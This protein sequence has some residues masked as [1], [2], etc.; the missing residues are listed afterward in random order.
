M[1]YLSLSRRCNF[2]PGLWARAHRLFAAAV[3]ALPLAF[4]L[5]A[6]DVTADQLR[7][8]ANVNMAG[9]PASIDLDAAGNI[10]SIVGDVTIQSQ[11]E[12]SVACD[13]QMCLAAFNDLRLLKAPALADSQPAADSWIGYAWNSGKGWKSTLIPGFSRDAS[14][15]GANSPVRGKE[16]SADPT[17]RQGADGYFFVSFIAFN[18]GDVSNS[19]GAIGKKGVAAIAVFQNPGDP[20]AAPIYHGTYLVDSGG[21]GQLLDKTWIAVGPWGPSSCGTVYYAETVFTGSGKNDQS[22]V[23]VTASTDCG[24]TWGPFSHVSASF[25]I[26]QSANLALD[27]NRGLHVTWR[28]FSASNEST[29]G[30]IV[31]SKSTNGGKTWSKP[32]VLRKLGTWSASRAPDQPTLPAPEF[33][34]L[35][36][37]RTNAYPTMCVTTDGVIRVVF[38]ER[39]AGSSDYARIMVMSSTNGTSWTAAEPVEIRRYSDGAARE[40]NQLMPAIACSGRR[41]AVAWFDQTE[42][43]APRAF[44]WSTSINNVHLFGPFIWDL[45]PPPPTHTLDVRVAVTGPNGKFGPGTQVTRYPVGIV[46]GVPMQTAYNVVNRPTVGRKPFIGDYIDLVKDRDLV[47]YRKADGTTGYRFFGVNPD[48]T[49]HPTEKDE[50]PV[51]HAA[52]ADNRDILTSYFSP[53]D[54]NNDSIGSEPSG[55]WVKVL[56]NGQEVENWQA[57]GAQCTPGT[58]T[59][60]A[61]KNQNPYTSRLSF[62]LDVAAFDQ[63]STAAGLRGYAV[64]VANTTSLTRQFTVT[65]TRGSFSYGAPPTTSVMIDVPGNNTRGVTL[66][67]NASDLTLATVTVTEKDLG[68]GSFL[69]LT[70]SLIIDPSVTTGGGESHDVALNVFVNSVETIPNPL[71]SPENPLFNPDNPLFNPD[72][73]LFNPD[74]PLFNPDNPLFNPDNPLFNPDNPLFSPDNPLFN[75]DNPLF[76]PDNP[77]FNP[78]NSAPGDNEPTAYDQTRVTQVFTTLTNEGTVAT[79]YDVNTYLAS[80]PTDLIWQL[81]VARLD[82]VPATGNGCALNRLPRFNVVTNIA[83]TEDQAATSL[84]LGE[85]ETAVMLLRVY[86]SGDLGWTP[87]NLKDV[88]SISVNSQAPNTDNNGNAAFPPP[89]DTFGNS[90]PVAESQSVSTPEDMAVAITLGAS[91]VDGDS[92]T[93]TILSMPGNG[94]LTGTAPDV[95]YTPGA[96]FNGQ[97]SFTFKASDGGLESNIA[98]VSITVT[99]VN[100]APVANADSASAV[101]GQTISIAVLAND[102]DID[103]AVSTL[104]VAAITQQPTYGV[105]VISGEGTSINYTAGATFAG[106]DTFQYTARD[107]AG[108]ISNAATVTVINTLGFKGLLSPYAPPPKSFKAG[109]SA[110]VIFQYT[111][112]K[113][114]VVESSGVA[115]MLYVTFIKLNGAN[116]NTCNGGVEDPST[117]H[118]NEDTPG[119]SNFQYFGAA[120]PHPTHGPNT[121][122]FNWT[123]PSA[124]CWRG[125]IILDLNSDENPGNPGDQVNG[126]FLF[127]VKL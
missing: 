12:P 52:W 117:L 88:L 98:T 95:V 17:V 24:K 26:N 74:N 6:I 75:P 81:L 3:V 103:D 54:P 105:A 79:A 53:Y 29:E 68:D 113:G 80:L 14:P 48:G 87:A 94:T 9:G 2:S 42:D 4:A 37:F 93:Y 10:L 124:G 47:P 126:P 108:A 19:A 27:R 59:P 57:P 11:S 119:N 56:Q 100:D 23:L 44:G 106:A 65:T 97:D 110:P 85:G 36:M 51:F 121:H 61:N 33:E 84:V 112:A 38:A 71:F 114:T 60:T 127:L 101:V 118:V 16:A 20:D 31:Y 125:R 67:L 7:A 35:R 39:P 49:E 64:Y 102:T 28:V 91:D 122:Q 62:G 70:R 104:R 32:V 1:K 109:S 96:N 107:L 22:K 40:G 8:G 50:S 72:N 43:S 63:S 25:G 92:L 55:A 83:T 66:F 82:S 76:N 90:A 86:H 41:A 120:N 46:A 116:T 58:G 78:D 115:P 111:D 21:S 15:E 73:P 123:A 45:I 77:L 13:G 69:K 5:G 99:P 30:Q 18:R 89:G 34:S